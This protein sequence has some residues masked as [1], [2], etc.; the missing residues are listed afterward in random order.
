MG[1]LKLEA[2]LQLGETRVVGST[3][4][5]TWLPM[6]FPWAQALLLHTLP[7]L[8]L[9]RLFGGA[10]IAA[11][12]GTGV[13]GVTATARGP[14]TCMQS[15]LLVGPVLGVPPPGA[16]SQAPLLFLKPQVPSTIHHCWGRGWG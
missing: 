15:P 3:V 11:A 7:V 8:V 4:A 12:R 6:G 13:A 10:G 5:V 14:G 2:P 1:V 16:G 9:Y